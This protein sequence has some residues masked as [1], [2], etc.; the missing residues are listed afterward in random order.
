MLVI[1][2]ARDLLQR[3]QRSLV[4]IVRQSRSKG[5]VTIFMSQSPDDYDGSNEDFLT[6]VGLT[7]AFRTNAKPV[8]E[9]VLGDTVDLS[10]LKQVI[11]SHGFQMTPE[12]IKEVSE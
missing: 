1:D 10:G 7:V 9:R 3:S 4:N 6:N 12:P 8:P 11:A 2:E 5:G